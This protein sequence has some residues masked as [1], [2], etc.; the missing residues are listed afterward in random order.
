M[1]GVFGWLSEPPIDLGDL[2][3]VQMHGLL[4]LLKHAQK[5]LSRFVLA[6]AWKFPQFRNRLF[7]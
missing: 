1:G 6:F 2:F 3:C 5:D 7:E 4:V